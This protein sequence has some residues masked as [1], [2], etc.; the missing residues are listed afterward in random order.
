MS[1]V[2]NEDPIA[3]GAIDSR[4]L[5]KAVKYQACDASTNIANA[6]SAGNAMRKVVTHGDEFSLSIR[7]D[8]IACSE[9][10]SASAVLG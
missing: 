5:T 1:R 10:R 2:K 6:A 9:S 3:A 4:A 8:T 7:W